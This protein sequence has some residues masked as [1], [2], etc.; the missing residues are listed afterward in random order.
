M[1]NNIS[2]DKWSHKYAN[3]NGYYLDSIARDFLEKWENN[4]IYVFC[5]GEETDLI[6][7]KIGMDSKKGIHVIKNGKML[8]AGLNPKELD[9][10]D[11]DENTKF[12]FC[13]KDDGVVFQG[14][15][16]L[17]RFNKSNIHIL[18]SPLRLESMKGTPF[19]IET[20]DKL[21]DEKLSGYYRVTTSYKREAIY[22][23]ICSKK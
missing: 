18:I 5:D 21:L 15:D 14:F 20:G 23:L 1:I 6:M 17:R 16:I 19:V 9:Q 10:I 13:P 8:Y 4:M 2:L 22:K 3:V 11:L 12:V 7:S